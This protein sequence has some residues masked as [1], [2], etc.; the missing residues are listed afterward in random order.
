MGLPEDWRTVSD[1]LYKQQHVPELQSEIPIVK[2]KCPEIVK[3]DTY[4]GAADKTFWDKFP[5]SELPKKVSTDLNISKLEDLLAECESLLTFHEVKRANRAIDNFK[6]EAKSFQKSKLPACFCKNTSNCYEF[7][8]EIT[9]VIANW[10]K[11][12]FVAGPFE[13]PPPYPTFVLTL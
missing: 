1:W 12:G 4:E 7:G 8:I 13:S 3:L 9:D 6:F 10:T 2:L 11:K 5:K